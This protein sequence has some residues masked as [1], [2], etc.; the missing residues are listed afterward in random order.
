MFKYLQ[1]GPFLQRVSN[2]FELKIK[3]KRRKKQKN[4]VFPLFK[5]LVMRVFKMIA[6][7]L[8]LQSIQIL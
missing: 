2:V 1:G 5:L 7:G 3:K 8:I 4:I 6:K